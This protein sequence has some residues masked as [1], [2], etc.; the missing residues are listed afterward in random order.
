ML[1]KNSDGPNGADKALT[2]QEIITADAQ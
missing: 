1:E 2:Q